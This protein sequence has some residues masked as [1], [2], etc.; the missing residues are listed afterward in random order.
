LA[1]AYR[2]VL[3]RFGA[4]AQE[5]KITANIGSYC[6]LMNSD[7]KL[8]PGTI[9]KVGDYGAVMCSQTILQLLEQQGCKHFKAFG[10]CGFE[11]PSPDEM[12]APSKTAKLITNIILRNFWVK[13]G[14]EHARKK[15]VEHLTKVRLLA[16][17]FSPSI[18]HA[19]FTF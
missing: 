12:P 10:A 15:A 3:E 5:F 13:I 17:P 16:L 2:R 8:L 4:E 7:L 11:F 6:Q 14:R 9:S 19:R 1:S 18:V